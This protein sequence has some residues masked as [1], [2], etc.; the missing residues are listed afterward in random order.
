MHIELDKGDGI[1]LHRQLRRQFTRLIADNQIPDGDFL[2][3]TRD[4][5]RQLGISRLTVLKAF[6]AMQRAGMVGVRPGRGY[7]VT[8]RVEQEPLTVHPQYLVGVPANYR[9]H[10]EAMYAETVRSARDMPLSFAAGYPDIRLLPL[11]QVRHLSAHWADPAHYLNLVYHAPGGH[12][13]LRQEL[14]RYLAKRGIERG[15]DLDLLVT[16]GAQHALDVF[17]RAFPKVTGDVAVESPTYYGALAV[18]QVNGFNQLPVP[19]DSNGLSVRALAGLCRERKFDFLYTNPAYNNPSGMTL[20][21]SRRRSLMRLAEDQDFIV[22]EDDTY[23]D[24]G[25]TGAKVRSLMTFGGHGRVFRIGSFSKSFIP[26]LRMGYIVGPKEQIQHMS[27]IH[28]VNN[29]CSSTLSQVIM[30]EA[31]ASGFYARHVSRMRRIYNKRRRVMDEEIRSNFPAECCYGIP[32]GGFFFWIRLPTN[33]DCSELQRRCNAFGVDFAPGPQFSAEG[34]GGDYIRLNFT[35][36]DEDDI[37]AGIQLLASQIH[38]MSSQEYSCD[39]SKA[40]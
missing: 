22:L 18:F 24:L 23:A 34:R 9:V 13:A 25:L 17:V 21:L 30:A 38:I 40:N 3:S 4:V 16:N 15:N 20:P 31:L 28:G 8:R 10:F 5:A 39:A 27:D 26:G 6:Q 12:P 37:R 19:Q 14:W 7:Y 1:P 2:P 33:V 35:L 11:K 29:M 36:L 32:K